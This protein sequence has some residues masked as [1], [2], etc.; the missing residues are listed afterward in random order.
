MKVCCS[1]IK[2]C[3]SF[4]LA[5]IRE[6]SRFP[7]QNCKEAKR[8]IIFFLGNDCRCQFS[9][10]MTSQYLTQSQSIGRE[11]KLLPE[12]KEVTTKLETDLEGLKGPLSWGVN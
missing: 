6:S 5:R 3:F 4:G 10:K 7:I 1:E 12:A 9:G 8:S 11:N 2:G